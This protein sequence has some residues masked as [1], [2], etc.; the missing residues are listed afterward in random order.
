[1]LFGAKFVVRTVSC[2]GMLFV[3]PRPT[4]L[5]YLFGF[6]GVAR[7]ARLLLLGAGTRSTLSLLLGFLRRR[8]RCLPSRRRLPL[9]LA[10]LWLATA[11]TRA[12]SLLSGLRRFR[13]G[14]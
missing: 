7:R 5:L 14:T 9:P 8:R 6:A 13:Y 10:N 1:M 12:V 4:V 3:F 11:R 2:R